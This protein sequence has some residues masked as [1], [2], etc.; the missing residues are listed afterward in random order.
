MKGAFIIGWAEIGS[1]LQLTVALNADSSD[2]YYS[3]NCLTMELLDR[4][5]GRVH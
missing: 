1:T 5:L 4:A 3:A 2:D